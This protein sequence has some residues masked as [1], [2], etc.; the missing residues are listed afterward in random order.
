MREERG[1][2]ERCRLIVI[3]GGMNLLAKRKGGV[4][5]RRFTIEYLIRTIF[6]I[7]VAHQ[8]GDAPGHFVLSLLQYKT[9]ESHLTR[10]FLHASNSRQLI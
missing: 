3:P 2:I 8:V 7:A 9:N 10:S 5:N 1:F 4:W 6:V